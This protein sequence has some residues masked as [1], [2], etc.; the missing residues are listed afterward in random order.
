M[1]YIGFSF[2]VEQAIGVESTLVALSMSALWP[3]GSIQ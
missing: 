3:R 1:R 2:V